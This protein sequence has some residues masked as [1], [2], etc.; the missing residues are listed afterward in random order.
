MELIDANIN[1]IVKRLKACVFTVID[2]ELA[3]LAAN[4]IEA[5]QASLAGNCARVEKLEAELARA[6][7][8]ISAQKDRTTCPNNYKTDQ[9]ADKYSWSFDEFAE[10]WWNGGDSIEDC[11]AQARDQNDDGNKT[12]FIGENRPFVVKEHIRADI[13]L[14][15]MEEAAF[16]FCGE[17]GGEWDAYDRRKRH[18]LD[19]LEAAITPIIENWMIKYNHMPHFSAVEN[20]TEY[21][22]AHEEAPHGAENGTE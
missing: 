21:N 4:I 20:I 11:I 7:E 8:C 17:I 9:A 6:M 15:T 14:E 2:P 18:E 19:E 10:I 5:Q 13:L 22:L 12:V 3:L 16:D 1:R